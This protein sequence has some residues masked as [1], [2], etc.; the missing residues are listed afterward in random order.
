MKKFFSMMAAVAAMFVFA[1]CGNDPVEGEENKPATKTQL[2]TPVVT[3]KE[4]GETSFT[5]EWEAVENATSYM[6]Y[7]DKNNQP[8]TAETSYTFTD[9]NAGTYKPRVKAIAEGYEDSEYSSVVEIVLTGLTNADWFTQELIA[10]T[11]PTKLSDDSIVYPWNAVLYNWKGTGV[12]DI[13]YAMF[14]TASFETLTKD[15]VI[16]KMNVL[17]NDELALVLPDVNGEEGWTGVF[18]GLYGSTSYT[19]CA[20]VT[21]DKGIEYYTT[22]AIT[23]AEAVVSDETKAWFGNWTAQTSKLVDFSGEEV[24]FTDQVTEFTYNISI[25]EGTADQVYIDGISNLG[26]DYPAFGQVYVDDDG[27]SYLYIWNWQVLSQIEG[28]YAIWYAFASTM[29]DYYFVSGDYPAYILGMTESGVTFTLYEG[30]LSNNEPFSVVAFDLVAIDE[31]GE[32]LGFFNPVWKMGEWTNIAK[33]DDA[34]ATQSMK[35]RN[36]PAVTPATASMVVAM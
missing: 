30:T 13:Q 19:L 17:S 16:E 35:A 33:V 29:G 1:S 22:T 3:V 32:I 4:K 2:E 24:V 8:T 7:F 27:N 18:T 25:I 31:Q 9:L 5:I 20:L 6:I 21:N 23:T 11:E 15:Q 12:A 26:A 36:L 34:P 28:G 10:I 14:E